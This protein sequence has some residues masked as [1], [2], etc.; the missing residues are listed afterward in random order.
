MKR[1]AILLSAA[2]VASAADEPLP[3]VLR[4]LENLGSAEGAKPSEDSRQI[5]YVTT[6][7]GSRQAAVIPLDGGYPVQLTAERGGVVS[8]RWS[9][10]DSHM[11][12]AV[13]VRDGRRR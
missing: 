3:E 5:A 7:F 9:P 11:L 6:L 13:A 1:L 12:V 4:A 10:S 8:V 2:V